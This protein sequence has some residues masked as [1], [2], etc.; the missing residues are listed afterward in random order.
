MHQNLSQ[1]EKIKIF[2]NEYFFGY[3]IFFSILRLIGGPLILIMGLFQYFNGNTKTGIGYAGFMIIFGVY[4]TLKPLILILTR[5]SWFKNFD[6]DY[7]IEPEKII[8]RS[9][10]SKSELD[11]SNLKAILKRKN[12]F[13]LKT[14]SNQGIYLPIKC[15]K[16]NEIAILDA[17][18]KN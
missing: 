2:L 7:D 6:L 13:A 1:F 17:L 15:L 14:K 8:I 16:A 18:T 5:K 11:Y 9:D 4:Y 12:Y 10:K 3:G